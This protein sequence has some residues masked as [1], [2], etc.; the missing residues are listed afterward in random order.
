M[1]RSVLSSAMKDRWLILAATK[2]EANMN[3]Y[4]IL[5]DCFLYRIN[6]VGTQRIV[7]KKCFVI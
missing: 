3:I 1:F 7:K 4:N 6:G 2:L 5:C